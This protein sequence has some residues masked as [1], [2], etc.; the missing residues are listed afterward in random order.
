M[1]LI[2]PYI[3]TT[4]YLSEVIAEDLNR[5]SVPGTINVSTIKGTNLLT[6]TV[7]SWNA[8]FAYDILQS[9]L[10]NYPEV[11]QFVVGQTE[12]KLI[13]DVRD[14]YN[15]R[16]RIGCTG[17]RYCMPCPNGV[18]IP[19]VFSIW[20]NMSLYGID[21]KEDFGYKEIVK[22]EQTPANCMECGAC[23][24]ACPQHLSI[25]ESLKQAWKEM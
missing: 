22:K 17:C 6:I 18:A 20:N 13:D 10:K 14:A 19:R 11:A 1:G 3:L 25:M 8:N 2:F 5:P 9:V 16:I 23:E 4:G 21:P 12:L 24:A 15:S 7:R